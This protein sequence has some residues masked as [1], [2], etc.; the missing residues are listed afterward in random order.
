MNTGD[1]NKVQNTLNFLSLLRLTAHSVAVLVV[2]GLY[3]NS[4]FYRTQNGEKLKVKIVFL[5]TERCYV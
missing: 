3:I 2:V 5:K 1:E 4:L